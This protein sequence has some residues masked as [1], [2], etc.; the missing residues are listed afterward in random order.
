MIIVNHFLPVDYMIFF[1]K[2]YVL[3]NPSCNRTFDWPQI[4]RKRSGG[5]TL[6]CCGHDKVYDKFVHNNS[7]QAC[8]WQILGVLKRGEAL[9]P[10]FQY[11]IT[12]IFFGPLF[13]F[14]KQG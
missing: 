4:K 10:G 11:F 2:P 7:H 6:H 12:L 5:H 13:S 3:Q 9:K 1:K 8:G 14:F